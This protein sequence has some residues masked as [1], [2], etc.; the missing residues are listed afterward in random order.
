MS[1][2][3]ERNVDPIK[4]ITR[5]AIDFL[6]LPLRGFKESYRS[7]KSRKIIY[8]SPWCRLSVIWGG[9]DYLVGNSINIRYGRLHAEN[10]KASMLWNG[11]E[12]RCWHRVEHSL[13][14]LD[15]RSPQETADLNYSHPIIKPFHEE[16]FQKK[17][18]RRQPELIAQIH[19]TIWQN[20]DQKLFELFDLNRSDLWQQY[21]EFLKEVY[22][23]EGR[24]PE[25]KPPLDK[26]C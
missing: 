13:H 12:C 25:V 8:D 21:R 11:E 10:E 14:F 3:D 19:T 23:I 2:V 24:F 16:E 20:Y 22:D 17:F 15:K 9:W 18:Y 26:V 5:I 6:Q 4:E 7:D 1:T